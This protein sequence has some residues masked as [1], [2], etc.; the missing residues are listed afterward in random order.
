[1]KSY[2][3]TAAWGKLAYYSQ[4]L[5][6]VTD[7][8]GKFLHLN[9]A[10]HQ[11]LGYTKEEMVGHLYSEFL[12]PEDLLLSEQTR[13]HQFKTSRNISYE[14][15]YVH[16]NGQI[17]HLLW[18]TTWSEEEEVFYAVG[19]NNTELKE[20]R[21]KLQESEQKFKALFENNPDII[22]LENT[23]GELTDVNIKFCEILEIDKEQVLG[24]KMVDFLPP[25]IAS[26]ESSS[27]QEA[28]T[29]KTVNFIQ[30]WLTKTG[31]VLTFEV[32]RI[33]I[34]IGHKIVGVQ[35][36]AVDI[37]TKVRAYETIQNQA[38]K[39]NVTLESITDAFLTV[40]KNWRITY[41]NNEAESVLPFNREKDI[42]VSIWDI[43]PEEVGGES[44]THYQN[45]VATGQTANFITHLK[46]YGK[47]F[48][49]KAYPY[50]DGLSIYF[51]DITQQVLS[52]HEL[53]KLSLVAS[54]TTNGVMIA[55][56]EWEIEWVNKGF[57]RLTGFSP[58]EA[59]GKKP[60]EF[61][62]TSNTDQNSF[63]QVKDKLLAGEA[64]FY[65]LQI[66]KKSGEDLW[67]NIDISPILD[68][69]GQIKRFIGI[70]TDITA[71]K[72][73]E[74]ELS[75]LAKDLYVQNSDLQQFTYIVS[76]NLRAPV[77]NVMALSDLLLSL[78]K[79]SEKFDK[80]LNYLRLSAY[81]LDNV[82]RDMNTI[83]S[84]RDSKGNLER[85]EFLLV[86]L[87]TQALSP[88]KEVVE[89]AGD[90]VSLNI[91]EN[92]TVRTNKAYL[93][94]IFYNLFSNAV[95]Y[96]AQDRRLEIKI[97][98]FG[99]LQDGTVISFSDNGRGF[100]LDKAGGDVFKLYKRFH[101]NIEGR[102]M[103]L[104]LVKSHLD[105]L[106]GHVEVS[107]QPGKGTRFLIHLP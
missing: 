18:S 4:D 19:R 103:G 13:L 82:M 23:Q 60:S 59:I 66:A 68:E 35:T 67:L 54:N 74:L 44:Y 85:E 33:P 65:E 39:L 9:G 22:F 92:F 7:K 51:D 91:P 76:H 57:T 48:R 41:L 47:W 40:D 95:K 30:D 61:L 58:E 14:N 72:R 62:H 90:M 32:E 42:G 3:N 83:L 2:L 34:K 102:G 64:V 71:L 69:D 77:A 107:S 81:E 104:F 53:E 37:T 52:Q 6:C 11:I 27:F 86:D 21:L 49:V 70:Q 89:K 73:S 93:Y 55:N 98:C 46:E 80:S 10:C 97:K 88:F 5:L 94:S 16:K 45:A 63:E 8:E 99:T 84:I 36:I 17:V 1:M 26:L 96:K 43:F 50:E 106:G 79:G 56:R 78:D 20:S 105:A 75:H 87:V 12:F 101:H 31:E 100:D 24:K 38:H 28:L 25:D 29:D 15:R